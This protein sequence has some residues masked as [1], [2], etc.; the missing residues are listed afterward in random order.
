M[1][2][3]VCSL[4]LPYTADFYNE[5]TEAK[6]NPTSPKQEPAPAPV[7]LSDV[8]R[9]S[10]A[11]S[12]RNK[13]D[14]PDSLLKRAP[15]SHIQLPKPSMAAM[16]DHED[17]F[18]PGQPSA[19]THFPRPRDPKS[20]VRSDAH[21][22]DWG[23]SSLYFNQPQLKAEPAP[24]QTILEYAKAQERKEA[25]RERPRAR[26]P[27]KAKVDPRWSKYSVVPAVQGNGG[28]SN[29]V[30]SAVTLGR[31]S[32]VYHVGLV[33]FPTDVLDEDKKKEIYEKFEEEY[34]ALAVYVND[35][36]FDGHYA[37]YCKTILWP[38]FHYIIP[39][40]PKSKAFLD[41]SW[42]FYV[43]IC[44]AFADRVVQN[45]KRGDIIWVHDYHLCLVPQMIRQKLPDA[46][47]GFFLHTAFPSSE[48]FR[49]LAARKELLD[50]MLGANLVAFQTQEYAHHFLQTCSRILSVEATEDGVQLENRFVNVWSSPIG[51][52]PV[53]LAKARA[54]PDVKE[55]IQTM[56]KRYEGKRVIVARDKLD[57]IRGVRQKLLAFELFL[58]KYPQWRDKVVLIQVATSTAEGDNELAATCA[59]I[60]TRIDAVHSTLTHNPLVFLRQ[61]IAFS[62][63]MALLSIADALAI[64]SLRE[65][66]NLTCHEFIACQDGKASPKKHGPVILSEF[67]GSAAMFDGAELGVNPWNYANIAEAF[68]CALEMTDE[69]K[70]RRF[71]KMRNLVMHHTGDFWI[72]NLSKH[73]A[74]VHEEQFN[75]DTMSIPRLSVSNLS[76]EYEEGRK[77]L[78]LLDYEGTLASYGS[79]NSTVLTSTERVIDVV[80]DLVADSR[81]IVYVMSGRT[82]QESELI[83]NRVKGLGLIAE[84][85]CF[86]R[87]PNSE[88]WTQFPNERK[89]IKWKEACKSILHYYLER[90]EGSFLEERHCSLI[91]HYDMAH[92]KDS[93]SRHAGDCA[94]HINDA[95]EQQRVKAVP[96]KDSVII[97]PLDFDKATAAQ[98]I[99][100]KFHPTERPDFLFVAGNDRTDEGVFRWAKVLKDDWTI[101]SVQTVTVG[102]RNSVAL[103]TL[104]NGSTGLLSVLSKLSKIKTPNPES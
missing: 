28:L 67:T 88:E 35:K 19:A 91:F 65:G 94:N 61:D 5:D 89:T 59:E 58:N 62:Q 85:G 49:C 69:E 96:T 83:F 18:T 7:D 73:L 42:C 60:V 45:Y 4:F 81:N 44:Q 98:H 84:N 66:M 39:D 57:N 93:S 32:D 16:L 77:R 95:C 24:P 104:T 68:R 37:H 72:S 74:K 17:F 26:Q 43:K 31:I 79:V 11:G 12:I 92:D 86:I 99:F 80:S 10:S 90:V 21:V 3:F 20:L 56:Q 97:E 82:V 22:S 70:L 100:G 53:A 52:D 36:D 40:H 38:V 15:P 46:Q 55:W 8:G 64:T 29:A 34:N 50:G 101:S 51:I 48:V 47:I 30:R 2:T 87:D 27:T 1:T 6:S 25:Q 9:T 103:S 102:N 71:S 75:R 54:E 63:Y 78:F 14:G 76:R 33:G 13:S 41:H 23:D